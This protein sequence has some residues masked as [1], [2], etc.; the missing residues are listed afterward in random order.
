MKLSAVIINY[1][2]LPIETIKSLQ[3]ADEII[4][5]H[6]GDIPEHN[7]DIKIYSHPLNGDFASQ[8]NY[9]LEKAKGEWVLFVDSDEIVSPQLAK[10]ILGAIDQPNISGYYLKRV[11]SFYNQTLRHGE[12]GDIKILRLAKKDAGKFCRPVHEY[13]KVDGQ[14][15]TLKHPLLHIRPD[16]TASFMDKIGYYS[17][18]DAKVLAKEGKPYSV[19]RLLFYPKAKFFKNYIFKL[20]FLDGLLGLFHAYMM[21]VQSL[22]VRVCQR[23]QS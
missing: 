22:S 8:R 14:T 17:P 7:L 15:E 1:K 19:F 21:A 18:M 6:D 10:E 20:G 2:D 9:A 16:F 23:C 5:I 4:V 12:T 13:W 11:D 3:F